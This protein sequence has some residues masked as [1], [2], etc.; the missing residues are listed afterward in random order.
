MVVMALPWHHSGGRAALD[1][2]LFIKNSCSSEAPPSH[3][4]SLKLKAANLQKLTDTC[5]SAN[6]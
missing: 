2:C 5:L 4:R 3:F 6:K 1:H